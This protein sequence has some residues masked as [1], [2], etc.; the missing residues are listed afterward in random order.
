MLSYLTAKVARSSV[1]D[2]KKACDRLPRTKIAHYIS[3]SRIHFCHTM[4]MTPA[5]KPTYKVV[6]L[7]DGGVG[8]SGKCVANDARRRIPNS[9]EDFR[10]RKETGKRK[11]ASPF[12]IR[13]RHAPI[14]ESRIHGGIR[15]HDRC[16]RG[17]PLRGWH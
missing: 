9:P 13:S 15:S 5:G 17:E 7:G 14:H 10:G 11:S 1:F 6:L 3:G 16:V 2:P 8:K 12:Y 4:Q